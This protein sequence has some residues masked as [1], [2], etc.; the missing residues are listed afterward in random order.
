MV[1]AAPRDASSAL[2]VE[3]YEPAF[4]R[5]DWGSGECTVGPRLVPEQIAVT[6][7]L[8]P[9]EARGDR[10]SVYG[11][12]GNSALADDLGVAEKDVLTDRVCELTAF[13]EFLDGR[14]FRSAPVTFD[15][16]IHTPVAIG[17]PDIPTFES[18]YIDKEWNARQRKFLEGLR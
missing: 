3:T 18:L 5:L 1:F 17:I 9:P 15:P 8:P 6:V 13:S 14:V 12:G 16:S 11:C 4:W 7:A 2:L 10:L